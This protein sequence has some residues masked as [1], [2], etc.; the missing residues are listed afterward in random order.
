MTLKLGQV[1]GAAGSGSRFKEGTLASQV[2][3]LP[4]VCECGHRNKGYWTRCFNVG[5]NRERP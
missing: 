1:P 4:W 5:C 2:P 3:K